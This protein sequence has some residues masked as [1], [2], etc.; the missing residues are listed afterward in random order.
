MGTAA[1]LR[2]K[3]ATRPGRHRHFPMGAKQR[4]QKLQSQ[5]LLLLLL[6]LLHLLL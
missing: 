2:E 3:M 6:L 5:L 1:L 4:L